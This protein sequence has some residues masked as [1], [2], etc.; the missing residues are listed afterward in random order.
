M[1]GEGMD[2]ADTLRLAKSYRLM[3]IMTYVN[4]NIHASTR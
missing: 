1:V 4:G 2:R 3:V